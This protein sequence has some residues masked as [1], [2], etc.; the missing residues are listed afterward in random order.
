MKRPCLILIAVTCGL[1]AV[2]QTDTTVQ[3]TNL[4]SAASTN[5]PVEQ[6]INIDSEHGEFDAKT[7]WVIYTGHV[8]LDHPTMKLTC[9]WL[10]GNHPN[11]NDPTQH[12][13]AQTNVVADLIGD[14][15]KKWHITGIQAVYYKSV[16]GTVT[17]ETVTLT[18]DPKAVASSVD[19]I[20]KGQP[21]VFDMVAKKYS[22]DK[23]EQEIPTPN[24]GAAKTN[25]GSPFGLP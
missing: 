17:N 23:F 22:G 18:G 21:L 15:G 24:S 13:I 12:I 5:A 9:E 2:A 1:A 3:T 7:G 8:R 6:E 4:P 25:H 16:R 10:T 20:I 14:Q 11:T 19:M